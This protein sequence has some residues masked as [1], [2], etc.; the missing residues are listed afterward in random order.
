ML[1]RAMRTQRPHL[2][3]RA[4]GGRGEWRLEAIGASWQRVGYHTKTSQHDASKVY[5]QSDSKA[6]RFR[7][8]PC[9]IRWARD[10]DTDPRSDSCAPTRQAG[11]LRLRPETS[12]IRPSKGTALQVRPPLGHCSVLGLRAATV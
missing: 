10:I 7:L 2:A 1:A 4:I 5:P 6:A 9:R 11:V 3:R 12:G 8:W